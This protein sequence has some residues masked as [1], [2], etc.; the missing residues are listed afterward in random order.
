MRNSGI[1]YKCTDTALSGQHTSHTSTSLAT[2]ST[3]WPSTSHL[4]PGTH[5]CAWG[6]SVIDRPIIHFFT[7]RLSR[8]TDTSQLS[9]RYIIERDREPVLFFPSLVPFSAVLLSVQIRIIDDCPGFLFAGKPV[10]P[11]TQDSR[12][13]SWDFLD[14]LIH[15]QNTLARTWHPLPHRASRPR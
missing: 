15:T 1:S 5:H 3:T 14:I 10:S 9:S 11:A 4:S 7:R 13:W 2:N 6:K 8:T 12:F